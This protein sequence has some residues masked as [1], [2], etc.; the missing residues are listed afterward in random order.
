M[1]EA[2]ALNAE[3]LPFSITECVSIPAVNPLSTIFHFAQHPHTSADD[4]PLAATTA[5]K[6][7]VEQTKDPAASAASRCIVS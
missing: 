5:P 2:V 4:A 1:V 6:L 7:L 3:E